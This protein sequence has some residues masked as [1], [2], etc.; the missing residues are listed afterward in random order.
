MKYEKLIYVS[1]FYHA[2]WIIDVY[3][4]KHIPNFE[5][6]LMVQKFL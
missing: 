5:R 4:S 3:V 1:N 2:F 6:N